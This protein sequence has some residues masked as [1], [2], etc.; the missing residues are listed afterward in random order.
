M[1]VARARRALQTRS[2]P[3]GSGGL[4]GLRRYDS[5]VSG[6]PPTVVGALIAGGA[7]VV[8]FGASALNT[9]ASLRA[10]RQIARDVR[11]WDKRSALYEEVLESLDGHLF[12]DRGE[13]VEVMQEIV[14]Y[15]SPVHLCASEPVMRAFD[16]SC[17]AMWAEVNP[18][19]SFR[20]GDL[21]DLAS[22]PRV[23]PSVAKAVTALREAIRTEIQGDFSGRIWWRRRVNRLRHR[24]AMSR[25]AVHQPQTD[26]HHSAGAQSES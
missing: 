2:A 3:G 25:L 1:G 22:H 19:S 8:G 23:D 21:R 13:L 18:S 5:G 24:R 11:L 10:N 26:A 20:V 9:R 16:I 17:Y 4:W 15:V 12:G 7:A 6:L 14:R